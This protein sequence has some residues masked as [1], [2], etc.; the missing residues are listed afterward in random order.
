MKGNRAPVAPGQWDPD[1]DT[2]ELYFLPD[3]F[4]EANNLAG[5]NPEKLA[6]LKELFWVEAE[7]NRVLPL[8]GCAAIFLGML[9]PMP[10]QTR[11]RFA[12]DVQN[13]QRG[14]IPRVYG[15]SYAIEADLQ[16]PEEGSKG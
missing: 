9:P 16:V 13:I 10:T 3:D 11:F 6:E 14:M 1:T 7:R 8:M 12:G 15:R 5:E 2:W 4:S